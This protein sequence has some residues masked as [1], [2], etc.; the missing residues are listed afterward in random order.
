MNM[1]ILTKITANK[2]TFM[3]EKAVGRRMIKECKKSKMKHK[4]GIHR[5]DS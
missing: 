1:L 2:S 4:A 5:E 3:G